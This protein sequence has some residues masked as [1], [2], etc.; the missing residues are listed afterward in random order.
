MAPSDSLEWDNRERTRIGTSSR[1]ETA[2]HFVVESVVD[3]R[4]RLRIVRVARHR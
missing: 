1:F 2:Q 3:D 4:Q